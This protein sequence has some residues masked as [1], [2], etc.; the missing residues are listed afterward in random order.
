MGPPWGAF[1]QITLTSCY[2][3]TPIT[4]SYCE[5]CRQVT[6]TCIRKDCRWQFYVVALLVHGRILF[7]YTSRVATDSGCHIR[8]KL[9][10]STV[11]LIFRQR[12]PGLTRPL[13][14]V[15]WSVWPAVWDVDDRS[16]SIRLCGWRSDVTTAADAGRLDDALQQTKLHLM[17]LSAVRHL[18]SRSLSA[19]TSQTT[20]Q[21]DG[22]VKGK[23]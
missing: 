22:Q 1:C 16:I 10:I 23:S 20:V 21:H 11:Q 2:I 8:A 6:V 19:T 4:V 5:V 7:N 14:V 13:P 18:R 15:R 3:F 17:S 9:S 12:L